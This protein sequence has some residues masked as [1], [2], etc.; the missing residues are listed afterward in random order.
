MTAMGSSFVATGDDHEGT[1]IGE[2]FVPT[3]LPLLATPSH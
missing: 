3:T 1:L 2:T